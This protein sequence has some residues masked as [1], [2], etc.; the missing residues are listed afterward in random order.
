MS[1][2]EA[3]EKYPQ[4]DKS[5]CPYMRVYN[6]LSAQDKTDLTDLVNRNYPRS[7]I[8]RILSSEGYKTSK[9]SVGNHLDGKC[10]C[11]KE[12]N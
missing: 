7:V 1:I 9:D 2:K 8:A 11:R 6:S 5:L 10:T 3:A 4:K 12:S